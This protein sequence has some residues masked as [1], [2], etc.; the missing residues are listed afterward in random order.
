[1]PAVAVVL[2][3]CVCVCV[4]VADVVGVVDGVVNDAGLI[5]SLTTGRTPV[6]R[7]RRRRR[8][9]NQRRRRRIRLG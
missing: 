5:A 4:C 2:F 1:M 8:S 3:A 7:R 6:G 9:S